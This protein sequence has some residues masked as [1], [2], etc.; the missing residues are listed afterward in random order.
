MVN[1]V[2]SYLSPE[3]FE[4][5]IAA[6]ATHE[7]EAGSPEGSVSLRESVTGTPFGDVSYV[8]TISGG[9]VSIDTAS[10]AVADVTFTQDYETAVSL[11]KGE[12][13]TQEVFFAGKIRVSGHLNAL[14]ENS[15]VLQGVSPAFDDVRKR[16]TYA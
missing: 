3:W 6:A 1:S 12:T 8:M 2:A 4:E 13:T 15:D 11:H 9:K 5:M 10:D 7:P 14:L 16:T